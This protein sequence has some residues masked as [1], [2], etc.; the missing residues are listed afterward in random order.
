MQLMIDFDNESAAGLRFA[1]KMLLDVA[2]WRDKGQ[3]PNVPT[4]EAP[5]APMRPPVSANQDDADIQPAPPPRRPRPPDQ[6]YAPDGSLAGAAAAAA[7]PLAPPPPPADSQATGQNMQSSAPP[8]PEPNVTAPTGVI[9]VMFDK[10]GMPWD[11]RIHQKGRSQKKDGTW[12]LQKGIDTTL[13]QSVTA[14]LAAKRLPASAASPFSGKPSSESQATLPLSAP[15]PPPD[16]GTGSVA[17]SV[18]PPPPPPPSAATAPPPP[19]DGSVSQFRELLD[20]ITA[21]TKAGKLNP[22]KVAEIVQSHG[23]PN[24]MA[25]KGM[26][27][28]IPDVSSSIDAA[29]LGIA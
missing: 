29:L 17:S 11:A 4:K 7:A 22:I 1:A 28:L 6:A 16:F 20:K 24:I 10:T 23:A 3:I 5:P 2:A 12:K 21:G 9:A 13:V 26:P 14:E 27:N 18:A 25:L 19:N 8:S 15:P